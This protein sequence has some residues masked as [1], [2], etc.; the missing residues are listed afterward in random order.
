MADSDALRMRRSRAHQA[1]IH[2]L[3]LPGRCKEKGPSEAQQAAQ[4]AT[5]RLREAV[6]AEFPADDALSLALA[7]RLV[8]LSAGRGPAAV[9]SLRALAELTAFQRDDLR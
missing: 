6:L 8:E 5:A 4:A 3:C 1:G 9:Q 7:Q 2:E